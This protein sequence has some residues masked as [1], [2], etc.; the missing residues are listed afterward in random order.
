M[1]KRRETGLP[2]L[3]AERQGMVAGCARSGL[4]GGAPERRGLRR[5]RRNGRGCRGERR[6]TVVRE[7]ARELRED[8]YRPHAAPQVLIPKKQPER[9]RP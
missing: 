9:F 2:V 1:R 6:G 7:M 4:A 8:S 5:G 3:H